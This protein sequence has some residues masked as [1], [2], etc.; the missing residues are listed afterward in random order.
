MAGQLWRPQEQRALLVDE[1][2]SALQGDA[3]AADDGDHFG[4]VWVSS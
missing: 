1:V 2:Q 4:V 3:I